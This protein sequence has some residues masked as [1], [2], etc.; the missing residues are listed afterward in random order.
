MSVSDPNRDIHHST[1]RLKKKNAP[2]NKIYR[3]NQMITDNPENEFNQNQKERQF[4]AVASVLQGPETITV[5]TE[6]DLLN[7]VP[8][9]SA[10]G[11]PEGCH[12]TNKTDSHRLTIDQRIM[13][14]VDNEC[15]LL[16]GPKKT[17]PKRLPYKERKKAK[18]MERLRN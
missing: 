18:V 10:I 7:E 4:K 12:E 13:E 5:N 8:F 15:H 2:A 17:N 6:I 9:N 3:L 1:K 16:T 11:F 14:N